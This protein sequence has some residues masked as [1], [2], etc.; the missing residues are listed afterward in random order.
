MAPKSQCFHLPEHCDNNVRCVH[1][2]RSRRNCRRT[3]SPMKFCSDSCRFS[4]GQWRDIY[5]ARFWA[6][7]TFALHVRRA[8]KRLRKFHGICSGD[9]KPININNQS[10]LFQ[11]WVGVKIDYMLPFS[12]G[13]TSTKCPANLRKMLGQSRGPEKATGRWGPA[14]ESQPKTPGEGGGQP[15]KPVFLT[16]HLSRVARQTPTS[17]TARFHTLVC[18]GWV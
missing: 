15:P 14:E 16:P 6:L 4:G 3:K 8:S 2:K 1:K 10:G 7:G 13:K 17:D 12:W 11:E 18:H 5:L 9:K